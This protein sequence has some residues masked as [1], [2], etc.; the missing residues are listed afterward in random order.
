MEQQTTQ[1]TPE[2]KK[3]NVKDLLQSVDMDE[4][5]PVAWTSAE[6]QVID[7]SLAKARFKTKK[8]QLANNRLGRAQIKYKM[9]KQ[10][11]PVD[12]AK[13]AKTKKGREMQRA[14]AKRADGDAKVI[15]VKGTGTE[16]DT[17]K[18]HLDD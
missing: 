11:Q 16:F 10:Q 13:K 8:K 18:F 3:I 17:I 9:E 1:V 6:K 2:Y 14:K 4:D 5:S 15:Q 7:A 12:E